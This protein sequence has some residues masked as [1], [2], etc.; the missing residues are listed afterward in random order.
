MIQTRLDQLTE[1]SETIDRELVR[2]LTLKDKSEL[3]V[4]DLFCGSGGMSLGFED[5]FNVGIAI[6]HNKDACNTYRKNLSGVV[7]QEDVRNISGVRGDFDGIVGAIAGTPCK[8]FSR[9][10]TRK[11]FDDPRIGLWKDFVRIVAETKPE[12][13]MIEN[14]PTI[15]AYVKRG[16]VRELKKLGYNV[17]AKVLN[18]ADYG[19]AQTRKRWIVVGTKRPFTFPNPTVT[20]YKTVRESFDEIENNYGF[21]KRRPETI[22]KFDK[23]TEHT[24]NPIS[25][26]SFNNAIRLQWDQ[27]AQTIVNIGKVYMLHPELQ[28]TITLAEAAK[29]QGLPNWFELTGTATSQ[30]EQ[31]ANLAPPLFMS[32]IAEQIKISQF[33]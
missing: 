10:N 21:E 28:S 25:D 3:Q 9:I 23:V 32:A 11:R 29:L 2:I 18:T 1:E 20:R 12:F 14:V 8:P 13:C 33:T 5:Y 6:D 26:G 17:I 7:R 31:V 27:P 22:A 19:V 24:W 4:A 30:Y 15:F 16:I